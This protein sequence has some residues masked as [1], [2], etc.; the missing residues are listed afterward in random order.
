MSSRASEDPASGGASVSLATSPSVPPALTLDGT[1]FVYH[2]IS[3]LYLVITSRF[4]ISPAWAIEILRRIGL[5]IQD[6]CGILS[7]HSIKANFVLVYELLDEIID[8]GYPQSTAP[9]QVRVS[10][11]A[12]AIDPTK[13]ARR[14]AGA[15]LASESD[16]SQL[17]SRV[18]RGTRPTTG[19]DM[20]FAAAAAAAAA[21]AV[22]PPA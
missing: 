2:R 21:A 10:I 11:Y 13:L 1:H 3:G 9:E 4:N 19:R 14:S 7:E 12:S 5:L 22:G 18:I 8:F 17:I 16:T 6:Y 15:S 20:G